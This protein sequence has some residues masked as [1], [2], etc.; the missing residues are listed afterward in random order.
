[1]LQDWTRWVWLIMACLLLIGLMGLPGAFLAALL[2][3]I[4]QSF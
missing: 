2:L 4:A 1:M 3:S